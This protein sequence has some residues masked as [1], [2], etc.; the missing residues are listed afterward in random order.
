MTRRTTFRPLLNNIKCKNEVVVKR[1]EIF[2]AHF[3]CRRL[4]SF[5]NGWHLENF[6]PFA[7]VAVSDGE[8]ETW[9]A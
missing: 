3:V 9:G 2:L 8:L 4:A 6:P 5:K 1:F 7:A